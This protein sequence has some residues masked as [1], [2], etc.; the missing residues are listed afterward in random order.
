M[1]VVE[2]FKNP[3]ENNRLELIQLIKRTRGQIV[4]NLKSDLK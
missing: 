2:N 1:W 3:I 4:V